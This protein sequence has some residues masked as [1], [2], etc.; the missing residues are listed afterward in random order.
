MA[1]MDTLLTQGLDIKVSPQMR[2]SSRSARIGS[3]DLGIGNLRRPEDEGKDESD[4]STLRSD[5]LESRPKLNRKGKKGKPSK[6]KGSKGYET[7]ET[8]DT[9]SPVKV[10]SVDYTSKRKSSI[11]IDGEEYLVLQGKFEGDGYE[12]LRVKV[13]RNIMYIKMAAD[14]NAVI[15]F[16]LLSDTKV[17]TVDEDPCMFKLKQFGSIIT[18]RSESRD[19]VESI[20]EKIPKVALQAFDTEHSQEGA[21]HSQEDGEE[22]SVEEKRPAAGEEGPV[23]HAPFSSL[24]NMGDF[25]LDQYPY[26]DYYDYEDGMMKRD[27]LG[28]DVDSLNGKNGKKREQRKPRVTRVVGKSTLRDIKIPEDTIEGLGVKV[29]GYNR[30][31]LVDTHLQK[32]KFSV[33][34]VKVAS[35]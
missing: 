31:E 17:T 6:F 15:P 14:P 4:S 9:L 24:G 11:I 20:L 13:D 32:P 35:K 8:D 29:K 22:G 10:S 18:F 33:R 2:G 34:R 7:D 1:S 23:T 25:D 3:A 27:E 30:K 16:D 26:D 5:A 28:D 21:E 19:I 12:D